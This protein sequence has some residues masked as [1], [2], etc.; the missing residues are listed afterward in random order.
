MQHEHGAS[1]FNLLIKVTEE[2]RD[3]AAESCRVESELAH[4]KMHQ[5]WPEKWLHGNGTKCGILCCIV[6]TINL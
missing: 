1:V 2:F 3:E 5:L 6:A 4:V